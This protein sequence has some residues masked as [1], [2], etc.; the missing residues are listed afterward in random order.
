MKNVQG[1]VVRRLYLNQFVMAIFG[2]MVVGATA[3][4]NNLTLVILAS[5][6]AIGLYLF[7]VYDVMWN[8]GAKDVAKRL[9]AEDAQVD[10]VKTPLITLLFAG[11]F[12]I[13][14]AIAYAVFWVV[15]YAQEL[16]EGWI[17]LASDGVRLTIGLTNTLYW[18]I[19]A[20]LFPHPFTGMPYEEMIVLREL[21]GPPTIIELTPPYFYFLFPIPMV[22]AGMLGYYVGSSEMKLSDI[23]RKLGIGSD[24]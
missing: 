12:N 4:T 21:Y 6:L 9:R 18:G 1:K 8:A 7:L 19:D 10:K 3:I 17:V 16:T 11:A 14:G 24:E 15:I 13:A 5:I 2:F 23:L 22:I 20:L